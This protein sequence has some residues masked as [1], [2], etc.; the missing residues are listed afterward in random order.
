MVFLCIHSL[1]KKEAIAQAVEAK[2]NELENWPDPPATLTRSIPWWRRYVE[3]IRE[4]PWLI[5]F[6]QEIYPAPF[7]ELLI[8]RGLDREKIQRWR[9]NAGLQSVAAA[10]ENFLLAAQDHELGAVWMVGPLFAVEEMEE[11][12]QVP[13]NRRIVTIVPLGYPAESP[14][15]PKRKPEEETW[16][17]IM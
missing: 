7:E 14:E 10:I 15:P 11:I 2:V 13:E 8:E 9:P 17:F 12:L 3:M 4:A 5:V 16:L 6:C 1:E